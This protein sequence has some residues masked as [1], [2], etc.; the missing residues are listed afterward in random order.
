MSG[1]ILKRI[2]SRKLPLHLLTVA[3]RWRPPG[4]PQ[5]GEWVDVGDG[6][7]LCLKKEGN[8]DTCYDMEGP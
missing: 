5:E 3:K 2:E 7:F 4:W 6:M 8:S 1:D